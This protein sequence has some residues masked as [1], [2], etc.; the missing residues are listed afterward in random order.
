MVR[1]PQG[2]RVDVEARRSYVEAGTGF[3]QQGVVGPPETDHEALLEGSPV[4]QG[5]PW[6]LLRLVAGS[7]GGKCL[8]LREGEVLDRFLPVLQE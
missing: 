5:V 2:M 7:S 1:L 8:L 6:N 3:P 4:L